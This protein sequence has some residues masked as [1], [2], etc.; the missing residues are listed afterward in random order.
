M[1]PA[2]RTRTATWLVLA[3][4]TVL[5]RDKSG[6]IS[7]ASA[8]RADQISCAALKKESAIAQE[9]AFVD[10]LDRTVLEGAATSWRRATS[11]PENSIN[12]ASWMSRAQPS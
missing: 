1:G 3:N 9:W 2:N 7:P 5:M 4:L 8:R 6:S 11:N 10:S 12:G